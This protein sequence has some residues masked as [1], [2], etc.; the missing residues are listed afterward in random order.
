MTVAAP[1][2]ARP[3]QARPL[4][5]ILMRPALIMLLIPAAALG[6]SLIAVSV[7]FELDS[8][9]ARLELA[10]SATFDLLESLLARSTASIETTADRLSAVYSEPVT[11]SVLADELALLR[12]YSPEFIT[13]LVADRDGRVLA[14]V[15]E[16]IDPVSGR[17]VWLDSDVSDRQYF[18]RAIDGDGSHVSDGF[19]GRAF[20]DD[21]L[22]GISHAIRDPDGAVVGIVQGS[23][24]LLVLENWLRNA[25]PDAGIEFVL[26]DRSGRIIAAS[27]GV[28]LDKLAQWHPE[29]DMAW[30]LATPWP[31]RTAARPILSMTRTGTTGWTL[32]VMRPDRVLLGSVFDRIAVALVVLAG[33][34]LALLAVRARY[35]AAIAREADRVTGYI[36]AATREA[37][38]GRVPD[39]E[40]ADM[41]SLEGAL[42]LASL[43]RLGERLRT[44][45]KALETTAAEERMLREALDSV[46]A[47]QENVIRAR[48]HDLVEI[49]GELRRTQQFL[50]AAERV[51]RVGFWESEQI[52]GPERLSEGA[53]VLLGAGDDVSANTPG[54]GDTGAGS[55]LLRGLSERDR[56]RVRVAKGR[57]WFEGRD[58]DLDVE[59]QR[60]PTRAPL[61]LRIVGRVLREN[62]ERGQRLIGAVL[63]VGS[64]RRAEQRSAY[65]A[66]TLT[67]LIDLLNQANLSEADRILRLAAIA[68]DLVGARRL[69]VDGSSV[70][71]ALRELAREHVWLAIESGPPAMTGKDGLDTVQLAGE[72][73]EIAW[74]SRIRRTHG[75]V[76]GFAL[77]RP[78]ALDLESE[79]RLILLTVLRT[80]AALL[81]RL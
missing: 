33:S 63:D 23:M 16:R 51:G 45:F 47:E 56:E 65:L 76:W 10:C 39:A 2:T 28:G 57:A 13:A 5:D 29:R 27:S 12:A 80:M 38:G 60:G 61:R 11:Q 21:L 30:P 42:V 48:T 9:R 68:R 73:I 46:V 6:I 20:G 79:R 34:L 66:D 31:G 58:L 32:T 4:V 67:A 8:G 25:L 74:Q 37:L 19:V 49:N 77:E 55:I 71:V 52:D 15:P 3:V 78:I 54:N 69:R 41:V 70:P 35:R 26:S 75:G 53:I 17:S 59:Y 50:D 64:L 43:R 22:I 72:G 44:A 1:Q 14:G 40:P 81:D 18:H 24:T 36:E 62:A 7:R